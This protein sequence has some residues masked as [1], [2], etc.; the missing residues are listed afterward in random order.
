MH[1]PRSTHL[2]VVH[3]ILRYLKRTQGKGVLTKYNASNE[4]RGS[5]D[6]DWAGSFDQ[7]ST[8][9]FCTFVNKNLVIWKSKKQNIVA[10]SS[11]ETE[12]RVMTSTTDELIWI[13][14]LLRDMRL[15]INQPM[16]I[17]CDNQTARHIASNPVFHERTKHIEIDCHLFEKRFNQKKNQTPFV[18]VKISWR[19]FL[20]KDWTPNFFEEKY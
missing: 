8:T 17:C 3:K 16:L 18:K 7:K 15:K 12:Y 4:I 5:S 1:V 20:L 10:Q 2:E 9:D 11:V 6:A 13:K 19:M 14:Q